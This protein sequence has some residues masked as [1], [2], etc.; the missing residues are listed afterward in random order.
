MLRDQELEIEVSDVYFIT[1]LS[2]RG[3]VPIMI[4][5]HPTMESMGMVIERVCH[6]ARKG[7]R[8][9][10]VDIQMIPDLAL[11]VVLHTLVRAT[12]SQ[13]PHEAT[14]MQLLLAVD[15]LNLTLYN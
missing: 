8:S 3:V 12:R 1:G 11:K 14:K 5:T 15:F 2:W 13:A 10:K 9:G 7:S 4:G 6:G